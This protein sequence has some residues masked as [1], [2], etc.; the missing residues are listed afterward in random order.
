ML[1]CSV[2]APDDF[3]LGR[4]GE[5]FDAVGSG[6][7]AGSAF[8]DAFPRCWFWFVW[9]LGGYP[10]CVTTI[11]LLTRRCLHLDGFSRN[12]YL[13]VVSIV[14]ALVGLGVQVVFTNLRARAV[15][16]FVFSLIFV[17]VTLVIV[18]FGHVVLQPRNS[19]R[20]NKHTINDTES[21][22][23][24][25]GIRLPIRFASEG[26]AGSMTA[27]VTVATQG[28][29][30]ERDEDSILQGRLPI[31]FVSEGSTGS[32]PKSRWS[33]SVCVTAAAVGRLC[34]V[35]E[36]STP[37]VPDPTCDAQV[38]VRVPSHHTQRGPDEFAFETDNR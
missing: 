35:D 19:S 1:R 15:S 20:R 4:S 11:S 29:D 31:R 13:V 8:Q 24:A 9:H 28:R 6:L 17:T 37:Q 22:E 36:H 18:L 30:G 21:L 33:T 3:V 34:D 25:R 12:V 10:L 32:A 5:G 38:A 16:S 7:A 2:H 26:S 23:I 27:D 14:V